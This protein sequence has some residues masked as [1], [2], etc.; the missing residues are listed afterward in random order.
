MTFTAL[1]PMLWTDRLVETI[2]FYTRNLKLTC[3][4]KNEDWGWATLQRDGIGIMLA[5]PNALTPFHK[6]LFTGSL[7]INTDPIN[8]LWEPLHTNS[9]VYYPT[10][11][12]DWG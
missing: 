11:N 2:D 1:T 10:E 4:E 9:R 5:K 3:V 8:E 12:F 7:Y 6:P